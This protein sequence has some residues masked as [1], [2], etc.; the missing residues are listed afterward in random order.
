MCTEYTPGGSLKMWRDYFPNATV[1]GADIDKDILFNTERI[2]TFYVNQLEKNS[3]DKMWD[4]IAV[5]NFDIII[6]DGLHTYEA[7]KCMFDNSF[8]KLRDGGIY[9]I[10]DV[11]PFYI[12]DL[13]LYLAKKNNIE[14][15]TLKSKDKKFLRDNNLIIVRK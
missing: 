5:N 6:D 14:V 12:Y 13:S 15:I 11:D 7:G 10:E 2:K 9:I 3:I 8:D 1:Y 4:N